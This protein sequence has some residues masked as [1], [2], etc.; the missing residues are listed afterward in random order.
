MRRRPKLHP[1]DLYRVYQEQREVLERELL[2]LLVLLALGFSELRD[3]ARPLL[4]FLIRRDD[5]PGCGPAPARAH[6]LA[7]AIEDLSAFMLPADATLVERRKAARARAEPVVQT[8]RIQRMRAVRDEARVSDDAELV[9]GA[10]EPP[11]E[12]DA[13]VVGDLRDLGRA[14]VGRREEDRVLSAP[15]GVYDVS[16]G[17]GADA[18]TSGI[19]GRYLVGCGTE[20]MRPVPMRAIHAGNRLTRLAGVF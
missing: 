13:R 10:L 4:R 1:I 19:S 12:L 2:V 3:L 6:I 15:F 14:D 16:V 18:R 5:S 20:Y 9:L 8:F 7:H 17:M 11:H